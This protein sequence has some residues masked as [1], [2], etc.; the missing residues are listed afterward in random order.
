MVQQ[1]SQ[2]QQQQ[3]GAAAISMEQRGALSLQPVEVEAGAG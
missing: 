3:T 1:R 2:Q